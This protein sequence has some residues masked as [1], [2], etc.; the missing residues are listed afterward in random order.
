MFVFSFHSASIMVGVADRG[1]DPPAGHVAGL[2]QREHLDARLACAPGA[3]RKLRR[4]VAVEGD[5]RVGVVVHDRD[6]RAR[7]RSGPAARRS[8]PRSRPRWGCSGSCRTAGW[9]AS[10]VGAVI[11]VQVGLE[12]R[13]RPSAASAPAR[14]R[15]AAA[16]RC[17]P[18]SRGRRPG[19]RRRDRA[20]PSRCGRRPPCRPSSGSTS[21]SGS[22]LDA[23]AA[24]GRSRPR[25]G[26]RPGRPRLDGY[27]WVS[28]RATCR[29]TSST[30]A[31]GVGQVG[32]AD[33]ERDHV[34]AGRALLRDL[35]LQL[36]EQVRRQLGDA[37]GDALTEAPPGSSRTKACVE[38]AASGS[39]RPARSAARRGRP[40]T[41]IVRSPPSRCTVTGESARPLTTAA[42][43]VALEPAARGERLPGAA[44]PDPHAQIVARQRPVELDV[45][46][47]G[48]PRV[49]LDRCAHR[50]QVE[51]L[52]VIHLDHAVRVADRDEGVAL[53]G[54]RAARRERGRAT[55]ARRG[56]RRS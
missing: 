11:D 48:K 23:E 26:G 36:G 32:I 24:L 1:A 55:P 16:P 37:L 17:R 50:R 5:L 35:A 49:V 2:G 9:R 22:T 41:S 30:T 25:P 33:A 45:G 18:G 4:H 15:P 27:W 29:C 43:A 6:A 38:V 54:R 40:T 3:C 20:S 13:A 10:R 42:T 46:A 14:R 34:D 39:A 53:G 47:V 7:G 51:R 8:R 44:L 56:R 28:G 12:A 31:A 19:R 52:G 21:V